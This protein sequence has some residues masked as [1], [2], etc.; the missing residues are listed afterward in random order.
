VRHHAQLE[1]SYF[2]P[3]VLA[4]EF[5]KWGQETEPQETPDWLAQV[6]PF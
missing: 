5:Y 4:G 3:P 2:E 1:F 6:T